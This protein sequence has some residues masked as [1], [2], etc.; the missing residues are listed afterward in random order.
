MTT[1]EFAQKVKA[2]YPEY[3]NINDEEL[4]K[5]V[6]EKYPEYRDRVDI[7]VTTTPATPTTPTAQPTTMPATPQKGILRQMGEAIVKPFAELGVSAVNLAKNVKSVA[8]GENKDYSQ[9]SYNL[10]YVGQ[11]KPAFTGDENFGD[12]AK[13]TVGYGAEVGSMFLGG[14]ASKKAVTTGIK[15]LTKQ[16]AI[17]GLKEGAAISGASSAGTSL[18]EGNSLPQILKD[19]AVGV[20][21]GGVLGGGLG[22]ASGA[23]TNKVKLMKNVRAQKAAE[24]VDNF[25]NQVFQGKDEDIAIAKK[26][27]T[28]LDLTG[29]KNYK[30]LTRL[31]ND[32]IKGI[33]TRLDEVLDKDTSVKLLDNLNTLFDV[34][35]Q[36]IAKNFAKDAIEQLDELYTKTNDPVSLAKIR[37]LA[38]K[39]NT[40]GLTTKEI[41][42][43]AKTYG[44][45]FGKKAFSKIGEPLTSVNAQNYENTRKGVKELARRL[46]GNDA[47]RMA[48]EE[49]T[50]LIRVRDLSGKMV[51][52]VNSLKQKVLKDK[53]GT[54]VVNAA[55]KVSD[56]MTFGG[57]KGISKFFVPRGEGFKIAN[58]LDLEKNLT[59]S[60][61]QIQKALKSQD[62]KE[63]YKILNNLLKLEKPAPLMLPAPGKTSVKPSVMRLP[64]KTVSTRDA[65]E[66]ARIQAQINKNKKL[67]SKPAVLSKKK[68]VVGNS[69][70]QEAKKYKTTINIQDKNDLEYLGRILSEDQIKD[71]KAGKMTNFRGTPY[72]DLARV[73]IISK[74]P[75]TI[76]QQLSGK[77]KDVKLKS[78]TFYHGT[79]AENADN[80]MIQGFK[81]GSDLPEET[82]RGGGYGKLQSSIS[83]TETAKDASRFSELSRGGKIVEAKLKKDARVVSISGI[84]DAT[85]LED[86][87]KYLQKEKIDAVYIGG[88]EKEL[89]VINPKAVVPTKSQLT[90]IWNKANKSKLPSKPTPIVKK[91]SKLVS[92]KDVSSFLTKAYKD[93]PL[94]KKEIDD[95]AQSIA[96]KYNGA[97]AIAPLKDRKKVIFNINKK[98]KGD[99]SRVSDIARNTIIVDKPSIAKVFKELESGKNYFGGKFVDPTKDP[100]G[101]SGYNTKFMA[102]NGHIAEIQI[103]TPEMIYAK[104]PANSAIGQLGDKVYNELNK[105]YN[106][107]GGKGHLYYD[108]WT[109]ARASQNISEA[110]SI[111]KRSSEY[112]KLFQ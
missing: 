79:S 61:K 78:D 23:V 42:D 67:P 27:L 90:D 99:I 56:F 18:R 30:D 36:K 10:P 111:E 28:N 73:N 60:L 31:L 105:R 32:N 88:G 81:Q 4:A 102:S 16:A 63:I 110:N 107:I 45:E 41:N 87:I 9:Q 86:Y 38:T 62:E 84:E 89:V 52:K 65:E 25:L 43:L 20:V 97:V 77:I 6:L 59:K 46:Y 39:A 12:F 55:L 3:Q 24:G 11:T 1:I 75:K 5:K 21:G 51:N 34:D 71:I 40:Q 48:D 94:A 76:E 26:A 103:N 92:L 69:L 70:E 57:L 83:L 91:K 74:T 58:A 108:D 109:K 96:S 98:Y 37:N 80:I 100:L 13:K 44:R 15:G 53:M 85:D 93:A 95:Y 106:G 104:E 33:S 66:I 101:Y 29:V 17:T 35:G 2:K 14:G 50:N 54:R 68:E 49:L 82:F 64:A 8:T 22:V 47:P 72:E 7:G 19:T 112:Y